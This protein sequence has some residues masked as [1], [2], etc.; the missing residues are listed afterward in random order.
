MVN[1]IQ[2]ITTQ[3]APYLVVAIGRL[4]YIGADLAELATVK[5]KRDELAEKV[6]VLEE[7]WRKFDELPRVVRGEYYCG[8]SGGDFG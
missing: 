7:E 5:S 4:C 6:W 1:D 8:S 2:Y 3:V